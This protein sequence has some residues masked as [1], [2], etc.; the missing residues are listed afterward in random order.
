MFMISAVAALHSTLVTHVATS[1]DDDE[2][3]RIIQQHSRE[4]FV[5]ID[6]PHELG[7]DDASHLEV[8]RHGVLQAE[9]H[10]NMK[11]DV[12]VLLLG[13]V[14]GI[15]SAALDEGISMLQDNHSVVSVSE[16]NMFN[17]Y[18]AHSINSQGHLETIIPQDQISSNMQTNDKKSAGDVYF[19]NGNFWIMQR[20]VIFNENN[21]SPFKWLGHKI[22]P[23][24]QHEFME[25]DA[26][27]QIH[28]NRL[29]AND[30]KGKK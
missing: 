22:V 14:V 13:N 12:V 21:L 2:I 29:S 1:T 15:D 5:V 4:D 10:Y 6:R 28:Y 24:V 25:L 18:R 3:K 16:F 20:D 8:I 7:R 11:Y 9:K 27:W 23:Y 19:C 30:F 17:P 26:P